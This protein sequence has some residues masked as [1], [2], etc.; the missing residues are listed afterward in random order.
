MFSSHL[1]DWQ[2]AESPMWVYRKGPLFLLDWKSSRVDRRPLG[3][4]TCIRSQSYLT[5]SRP[6]GL[7]SSEL[8]CPKDSPGKNAG[9]GCHAILKWIFL[10]QGSNMRLLHCRQILYTL[11]HPGSPWKRI[12]KPINKCSFVVFRLHVSG[13]LR[14]L[15]AVL[16][17]EQGEW[18][19]EWV[20]DK[21][22]NMFR[23]MSSTYLQI[24]G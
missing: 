17:S 7:S 2:I 4:N 19:M 15:G 21:C 10:T 9:V 24:D 8:L 22:D 3:K 16:F 20:T 5:L 11:S 6:H 14:C 13:E 18:P 23:P 1:I 12:V